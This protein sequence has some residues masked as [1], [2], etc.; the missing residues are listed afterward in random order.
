[1]MGDNGVDVKVRLAWMGMEIAWPW[2][3]ETVTEVEEDAFVM[4]KG[5]VVLNAMQDGSV[6]A[7]PGPEGITEMK[8]SAAWTWYVGLDT[9]VG[10]AIVDPD[11]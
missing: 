4:T 8:A 7:D 10:A 2:G 1:M 9:T 3:A 5:V 11:R 6:S